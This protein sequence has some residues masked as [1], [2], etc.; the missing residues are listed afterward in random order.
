MEYPSPHNYLLPLQLWQVKV[1]QIYFIFLWILLDIIN[2][3]IYN[4]V[5]VKVCVTAFKWLPFKAKNEIRKNPELASLFVWYFLSERITGQG[6]QTLPR[7]AWE[8]YSHA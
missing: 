5:V 3:T 2:P 8:C 7:Y 6:M 1:S 4:S